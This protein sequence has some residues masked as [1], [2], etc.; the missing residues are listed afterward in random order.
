VALYHRL[1]FAIH[2]TRTAC[3]GELAASRP[4]TDTTPIQPTETT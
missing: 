1:G 3:A 2:R 4:D